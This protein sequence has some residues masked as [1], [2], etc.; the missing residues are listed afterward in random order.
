MIFIIKTLSDAIIS[1][2]VSLG[3]IEA[4]KRK[5]EKY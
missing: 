2:V 3:L 5:F 1:C 4:S